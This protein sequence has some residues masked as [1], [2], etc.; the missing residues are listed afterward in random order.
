MRNTQCAPCYECAARHPKCHAECE[1]YIEWAKRTS[2]RNSRHREM[3]RSPTNRGETET[4]NRR[5]RERVR[6]RGAKRFH[7]GGD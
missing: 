3:E 7:N 4:H 1:A 2:A 6:K 5:L